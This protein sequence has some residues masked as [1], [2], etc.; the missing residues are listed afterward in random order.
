MKS[1]ARAS[2]SC[3]SNR[4]TR[5]GVGVVSSRIGMKREAIAIEDDTDIF[6]LSKTKKANLIVS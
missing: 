3:L 4:Y 5:D 1:K 2:S 6:G